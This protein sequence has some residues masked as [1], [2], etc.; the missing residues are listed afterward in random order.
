VSGINFS[1]KEQLIEVYVKSFMFNAKPWLLE[2]LVA[3]IAPLQLASYEIDVPIAISAQHVLKL[4]DVFR[5]KLY[6]QPKMQQLLLSLN[7]G[8]P[9][10]IELH[11]LTRDE[12]ILE[13]AF[14]LCSSFVNN[15][16]IAQGKMEI[17]FEKRLA[18]DQ[19]TFLMQET[20]WR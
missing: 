9:M 15:T 10:Q 7:A 18:P 4:L 8:P 3:M 1:E 16:F 19:F 14:M 5:K 2:Q 20:T 12:E 6:E 13:N 11:A 17:I